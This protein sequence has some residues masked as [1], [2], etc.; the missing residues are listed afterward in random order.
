MQ[1]PLVSVV[2][3]TYN[4]SKYV[5]DAI[6]SVLAQGY[7]N[8]EYIIGDDCSTDD[9]WSII[10]QYRDP[11]II[12]YRNETNLREYPNRNKAIGMA[13]GKYLQFID[14]DD[15][16]FL[17]GIETLVKMMEQFP[18]A[19]VAIQK[20]YCNNILFPALFSTREVL[21]NHFYGTRDML[22]SSFAANFFLAE[23][24]KKWK[25][26]TKFKSGDNEIRLR[27]ASNFPV[28]FLAGWVSWPRE[29]PG[30]ASSQLSVDDEILESFSYSNEVLGSIPGDIVEDGLKKDIHAKLEMQLSR[31]V[32]RLL[33]SGKALQAKQV[34]ANTGLRW[35]SIPR[36]AKFKP[37]FKDVLTDYSPANPYKKDFLLT[38]N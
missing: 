26:N 29:T 9:T 2:T 19:G 3:V 37:Q 7:E 22:S 11:R 32:L 27:F 24:L 31:Y 14:G 6:E 18:E 28:L 1:S 35:T 20:N 10:Q 34:L 12:A 5:R 15:V 4:S 16:L 38:A 23:P 25:L 36:L 33:F 17:N 21:L 13:T 30:Q 8:I